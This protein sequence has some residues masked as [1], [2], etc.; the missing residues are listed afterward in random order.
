M[1]RKGMESENQNHA[2]PEG[3]KLEILDGFA[4]SKDKQDSAFYTYGSPEPIAIV[5]DGERE[6]SVRCFGE[7]R[8][9]YKGEVLRHLEDLLDRGIT[10]DQELQRIEAEGGEWINNSWFEIYDHEMG[11]TT[12][13][14]FHT[15][16]EA[17]QACIRYAIDIQKEEDI[18]GLG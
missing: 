9:H 1:E 5:N 8:I 11:N 13:D 18:H 12:G 10:T 3:I 6:F 14:V 2:L 17:I 15:V 7:M 4:Y 16:E